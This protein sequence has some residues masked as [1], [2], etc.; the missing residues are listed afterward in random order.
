MGAQQQ[1]GI[2]TTHNR[3]GKNILGVVTPNMTRTTRVTALDRWLLRQMLEIV[4]NPPLM[5]SLWNGVEYQPD[6]TPIAHMIFHDRGSL[7]RLFANSELYFGDLYSAGRIEIKG[8]LVEFL[9]TVC[10]TISQTGKSSLPRSLLKALSHRPRVNSLHNSPGN[11]YHH[12]DISN[13][14]YSLWLDKVA[15]QYT[16]AYF[17][18]QHMEL[19]DAQL[20][21]MHHVCRKLD[22]KPGDTVVEAGCGWGGLAR[23]MARH[24]GVTVKAYNISHQQLVY[25]RSKALQEGLAD[26]VEYIE[27]DYRNIQGKYD[28]F[29]S[30]EMLEHVGHQEHRSLGQVI[31]RCL[32]P[33][34]RGLIQSIG[35]N[36][37]ELM[38]AWIEKRIFP[39]AYP[40]CL[41]EMME[42]FEPY[43]F[44]VQ[45][46]ENLRL[47]Y[48]KT[49]QHW[50]V[51]YDDNVEQIKA[52][53]DE[54]FAR[55]WRL[56]LA[57]SIATF[58]SSKLQLFQIMFTRANNNTLP[59]SR[60][61]LYS[62][63]SAQLACQPS[64]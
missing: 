2:K 64:S 21:K 3:P 13:D 45:D 57:G 52:E 24:Y 36:Q 27:D 11:I 33:N 25:A 9:V 39:G 26:R 49:L 48:V 41:R 51:R 40:L 46:V 17:S 8:D 18:D 43:K 22:L 14:F 54:S 32:K 38:N 44:S 1:Q 12:Y 35:R 6:D 23:F 63:D 60:S 56:Y 31:D 5:V 47:H 15:M 10:P 7:Y 16:C 55:A 19:E 42:I 61:H 20:A 50:L 59:W 28:V 62:Q 53:F 34:G 58:T 29:V 4:G 30:I 37:P